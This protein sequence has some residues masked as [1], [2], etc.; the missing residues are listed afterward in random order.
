M[1]NYFHPIP[2]DYTPPDIYEPSLDRA[3]AATK[4]FRETT[5]FDDPIRFDYGRLLSDLSALNRGETITVGE[6]EFTTNTYP[7]QI[8]LPAT[9]FVILDGLFLKSILACIAALE[10]KPDVTT[11]AVTTSSY[12]KLRQRRFLRDA[13]KTWSN[14]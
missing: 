3:T 11:V 13:R 14:A 8:K 9:E 10:I 1:D 12:L 2:D 4:H 7:K 6:F 5:N